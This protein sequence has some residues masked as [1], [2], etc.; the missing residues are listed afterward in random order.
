MYGLIFQSSKGRTYRRPAAGGRGFT[1]VELLVVVAIIALL[2]SILLPTLGKAKEQARIVMCMSNL[3]G[4]NLAFVFYTDE[5]NDW[6][7]AG[8]ASG[9]SNEYTWDS[10]LQ[11]YYEV[12]G[13]LHC[14]S[15]R[16]LR[17]WDFYGTPTE[18]RHPRS[19]AINTGASWMGPSSYDPDFWPGWVHKITEATY[20][21]DTILL[22]EQWESAYWS[23]WLPGMYKTYQG[24]GAFAYWETNWP[25]RG[26]TLDVHRNDD[27][28]NYLFCDG[29][30][31]SV[32][33]DDEKLGAPDYYYWLRER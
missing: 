12:F 28:A 21:T 16:L 2:V 31:M 18:N 29:H 23:T 11:P 3:K 17:K 19:F 20:P 26:P 15:D 14:P 22:A 1:L 9:G 4:L 10:I 8:S 32:Q 7:P 27:M 24:C 30:V 33:A 5:H 6:L 25:G 13:L